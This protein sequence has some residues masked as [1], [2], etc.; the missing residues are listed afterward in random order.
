MKKKIFTLLIL[1]FTFSLSSQIKPTPKPF[2]PSKE[3]KGTSTGKPY[4]ADIALT[5]CERDL[6]YFKNFL[7][8]VIKKEEN[9]TMNI[10]NIMT[11]ARIVYNFGAVAKLVFVKTTGSVPFPLLPIHSV[12]PNNSVYNMDIEG[13]GFLE[14]QNGQTSTFVFHY[15]AGNY[16]DVKEV[17]DVYRT[18]NNIYAD[19][20]RTNG[21]TTPIQIFPGF[22]FDNGCVIPVR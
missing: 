3:I 9:E 20:K 15:E 2:K 14:T 7:L 6:R 12:M 19:L 22:M 10:S 11:N 17:V 8:H 1:G 16:S 13:F 5:P 21:S 4:L 18:G